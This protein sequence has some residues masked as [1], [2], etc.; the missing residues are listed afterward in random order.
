[1]GQK[2]SM[3]FYRNWLPAIKKM[4]ATDVK[5][6]VVALM[7]LGLDG[8]E[9]DKLKEGSQAD[10]TYASFSEVTR[11]NYE[12]FIRTCERNKKNITKRYEKL[13]EATTSYDELPL[14]EVVD[15]KDTDKDIKKETISKEIVKKENPKSTSTFKRP[16]LE[17]VRAYCLERKN[18]VDPEAFIAFYESKGWKVGNQPMKNWKSAVITWEKRSREEN[19]ASPDKPKTTRFQNF[20]QRTYSKEEW[21]EMERKL[22]NQG[23]GG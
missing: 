19:K 20:Q 23:I 3:M 14:C 18:S 16:T 11:E 6:L 1:M 12:E 2:Q 5:D 9:A 17:E 13:P 8:I 22:I 7:E 15:D 21:A 4:K 10:I